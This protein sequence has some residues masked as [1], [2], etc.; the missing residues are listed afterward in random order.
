MRERKIK[1]QGLSLPLTLLKDI[2]NHNKK[3][4]EYTS[5]TDFVKEAIREKLRNEN[6]DVSKVDR[7]LE[8]LDDL[9]SI[10]KLMI[11]DD[12]R[13]IE[14]S[15]MISN[16]KDSMNKWGYNVGEIRFNPVFLEELKNYCKKNNL[17][18]ADLIRSA[19]MKVM[20]K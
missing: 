17:S 12:E 14:V 19:T 9:E 8:I 10:T 16:I 4:S 7:F 5:V 3:H 18:L 1:Y 6:S 2:K 15:N 13:F 20:K 11:N